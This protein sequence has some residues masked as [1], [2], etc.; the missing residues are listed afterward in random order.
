MNEQHFTLELR[1]SVTAGST[2]PDEETILHHLIE[3]LHDFNINNAAVVD[4][5]HVTKV[6]G[7]LTG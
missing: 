4:T 3:H 2:M 6:N 5:V 1:L 7:K